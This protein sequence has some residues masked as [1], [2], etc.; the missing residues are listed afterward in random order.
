MNCPILILISSSRYIVNSL[1]GQ[2]R[3]PDRG[4]VNPP[5]LGGG[6]ECIE[7]IFRININPDVER[8]IPSPS[9]RRPG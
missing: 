8:S 2:F 3:V 9:G 1:F 5:P 7:R 6:L 4:S